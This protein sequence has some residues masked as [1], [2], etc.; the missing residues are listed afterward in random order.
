MIRV[1]VVDDSETATV[2]LAALVEADPELELVGVARD[3]EE[4]VRL[5][6]ELVPD[7]VTM[8]LMMPR[9]SGFEA[10]ERLAA[11]G[12]PP[13]I[14][15]STALSPGDEE[16]VFSAMEMG[17]V[18]VQAKP[19]GMPDR[20]PRAA[21]LLEEIKAVGRA[22]RPPQKAAA[23]ATV[24]EGPRPKRFEAVGIAASTG[25]PQAVLTVL[26]AA[27]PVLTVPVLLVQHIAP[28]F[29]PGMV[30]WMSSRLGMDV[31]VARDGVA[32]RPGVVYVA[33]DGA[34]LL[35]ARNRRLCLDRESV[36]GLHR[37]SA[38]PLFAS[39]GEVLGPRAVGVVLTGMGRDGVEG[40]ETLHRRG[41]WVLAQD[42]AS[43]VVW[44]MPGA[45][46][47]AGVVDEVLPL[48]RI[49]PRLAELLGES[50]GKTA[51]GG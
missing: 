51:E 21:A 40:L 18:S 32:P 13:V 47:A 31:E 26:A 11:A 44:G 41:G 15:V 29:L 43:S 42:R 25:G 5:A 48:E 22:G 12:G 36:N 34:H 17:A 1:L 10:I 45:A 19:R 2:L 50:R 49:G 35:L 33:P 23:P 14:V 37:P 7:V 24:R 4:G 20:D 8:D 46:V 6:L 39:L 38:D 9:M 27:R 16:R 3:G 28:G 30:G